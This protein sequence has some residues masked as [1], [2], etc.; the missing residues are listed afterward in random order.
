[1]AIATLI[2]TSSSDDDESDSISILKLLAMSK[3]SNKLV[4]RWKDDW[5]SSSIHK[6]SNL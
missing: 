5:M 2:S 3:H 1:M 4:N 6:H